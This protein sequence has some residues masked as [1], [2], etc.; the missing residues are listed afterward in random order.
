MTVNE[1][2]KVIEW[3]N[4]NADI[5]KQ[6][7]YEDDSGN[8]NIIPVVHFNELMALL[9]KYPV[10][11]PEACCKP[12]YEAMYND[13][14]VKSEKQKAEI[15]G[16]KNEMSILEHKLNSAKGAIAMVEV[17][18]GRQWAPGKLELIR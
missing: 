11:E 9:A 12:N 16:L 1:L 8:F 4:Q 2:Q 17:I 5:H 18:Y 10:E 15:R 13:M 6:D 14:V 7:V 3:V